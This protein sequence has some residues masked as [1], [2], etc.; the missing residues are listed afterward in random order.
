MLCFEK[1]LQMKRTEMKR[2]FYLTGLISLMLILGLAV[3][4]C[5]GRTYKI[6]KTGPAGGIIFYDKGTFSDGW[7]YLEAAPAETEFTAEWGGVGTDVDGT[8]TEI[9]SG[10]R[11]TEI[12]VEQLG[13]NSAAGLCSRLDFKSFT[14]WFL[15]SK[16]EL[17]L[18]YKN[19]KQMGTGGL[20]ADWYWSSSQNKGSS[21][22]AWIQ[23]FS[24]GYH[25]NNN[26]DTTYP[27]RAVRAF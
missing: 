5:S 1:E 15:P 20:D 21:R 4:S 23:N 7:R 10:K 2:Y 24:D 11:N 12:I 9:G 16:D 18:M 22:H 26:K 17:D 8:S 25:V 19:L 6:G 13:A 27:V 3:T 14:D